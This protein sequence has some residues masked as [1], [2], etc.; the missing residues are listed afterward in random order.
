M[1]AKRRFTFLGAIVLATLQFGTWVLDSM[2]PNFPHFLRYFL[3][4][5]VGKAV[6]DIAYFAIWPSRREWARFSM[7]ML[8][9]YLTFLRFAFPLSVGQRWLETLTVAP[10]AFDLPPVTIYHYIIAGPYLAV[11]IYLLNR[12]LRESATDESYRQARNLLQLP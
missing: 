6:G 11:G 1:D 4:F 2:Y 5:L 9:D 3:F 7:Y 8:E 12:W 10:W